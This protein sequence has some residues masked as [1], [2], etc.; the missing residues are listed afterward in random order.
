MC[1]SLRTHWICR[2]S[3]KHSWESIWM[4]SLLIIISDW[5][6]SMELWEHKLLKIRHVLRMKISALQGQHIFRNA[7]Y[8]EGWSIKLKFAWNSCFRFGHCILVLVREMDF[9]LSRNLSAKPNLFRSPGTLK[10]KKNVLP[11]K[12]Q[13]WR[14]WILKSHT[15]CFSCRLWP[16]LLGPQRYQ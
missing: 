13:G 1:L 16:E 12:K 8:F 15:V 9:N 7:F 11:L 5:S 3:R 14:K 4:N 10:L 2:H 6:L